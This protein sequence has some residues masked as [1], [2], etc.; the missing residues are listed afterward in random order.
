VTPFLLL[1]RRTVDFHCVAATAAA[2]TAA[3][4]SHGT[5]V[6]MKQIIEAKFI[7][8]HLGAEVSQATPGKNVMQPLRQRGRSATTRSLPSPHRS[9]AAKFIFGPC[10][11]NNPMVTSSAP[12]NVLLRLQILRILHAN[13]KKCDTDADASN[14]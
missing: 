8:F 7:Y 2:A 1:Y 11:C 4:A 5:Y 10:N 3:A 12:L 6:F 9:T 14:F 13:I